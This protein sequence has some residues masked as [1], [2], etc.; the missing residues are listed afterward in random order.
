[1]SDVLLRS[2]VLIKHNVILRL[3]DPGQM[4]SYIVVPMVLMLVFKPL[5]VK[6]LDG[7]TLQA[8][9]GPLV[10]FSVFALGIVGN[11][12]LLEREWRTWDRLRVTRATQAELLVG[13]T[14]P[15][16]VV[17]VFQQL[18][19]MVYG[20]L[21]IGLPVPGSLLLIALAIAVWGFTLLSIGSA[22][23]TVV[24]S[25]GDLHLATDVG[26]IVVSSLGGAVVP[27][28]LMPSWAASLAHISPGYWGLTMIQSAVGGDLGGTLRCAGV[29]LAIGAV[30]G[31]FA[32]HRLSRGWGRSHLL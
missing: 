22:L 31:A 3:R 11:S 7:S 25:R 10:M 1:M 8:V 19:L 14:V 21:I 20:C 30:F 28:S 13:K 32:V 26:S 12:I 2:G 16:F 9:T 23:A 5:Y 6:A 4:I 27:V 17:L 18:V 29:C 15:I 24:R